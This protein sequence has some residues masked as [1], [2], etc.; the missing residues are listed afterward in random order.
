[1]TLLGHLARFGGADLIQRLIHLG[2]DVEAVE[3]V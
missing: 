3:D 1:M 2:D